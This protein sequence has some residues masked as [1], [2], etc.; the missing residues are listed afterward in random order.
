MFPASTAYIFVYIFPTEFTRVKPLQVTLLPTLLTHSS[1]KR[2]SDTKR[3]FHGSFV[4]WNGKIFRAKYS[5]SCTEE[6][7]VHLIYMRYMIWDKK[8]A[9]SK[10]KT[11]QNAEKILKLSTIS[12]KT[13]REKCG[14]FFLFLFRSKSFSREII[15]LKN[16][17]WNK[18]LTIRVKRCW[19]KVLLK[20][21]SLLKMK[22]ACWASWLY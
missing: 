7:Y 17:S 16:N 5:T 8:V 4:K 15:S 20:S 6:V 9:K 13:W 18:R 22:C 1:F 11:N 3:W 12:N 14:T 2:S 10:S 21:S 19:F